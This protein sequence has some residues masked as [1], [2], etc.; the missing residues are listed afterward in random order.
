MRAMTQRLMSEAITSAAAA[1]FDIDPGSLTSCGGFASHVYRGRRG[2]QEVA[3]KLTHASARRFE[4]VEAELAF[5]AEAERAGVALAPVIVPAGGAAACSLP[6]G[7]GGAFTASCFAWLPGRCFEEVA[8]TAAQV[9]GVGRNLGRL[10]EASAA[11]TARGLRLARG[12][13]EENDDYDDR[14]YLPASEAGVIACF[15]GIRAGLRALPQDAR[16]FGLVHSDGHDGN[17]ILGEDGVVRLIDFDDCE[18]HAFLYD[19]AVVVYTFMPPEGAE[20]RAHTEGVFRQLLRGYREAREVEDEDFAA[21]PLLLKFRAL[22]IHTLIAKVAALTGEP[23]DEERRQRR[24]RRFEGGFADL[25]GLV[26]LDYVELAR[27][28]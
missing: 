21:F 2:D 14:R 28:L 25:Q 7:E 13:W 1:H 4:E 15:D 27:G 20:L 9:E 24:I 8:K 10:H 26:G 23:P 11:L 19:L 5:V 17:M 3:L 18:R 12:S 22:M 16:R 6:D